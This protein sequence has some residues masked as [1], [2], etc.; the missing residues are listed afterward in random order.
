MGY[1]QIHINRDNRSVEGDNHSTQQTR[2][3]DK[4]GASM[5]MNILEKLGMI[6][7]SREV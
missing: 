6:I 2:M 3:R 7:L 5:N 1:S 4:I